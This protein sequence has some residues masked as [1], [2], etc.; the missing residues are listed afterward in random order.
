MQVMEFVYVVPR[1]QLFPDCTPHGF[2]PFGDELSEES[3]HRLAV[4]RGH[5]VERRHAEQ[6]P[7]LK[8][9]IPYTVVMRENEVFCLRRTKGGG[10]ARLHDKL[11]IGVGGHV[12]PIDMPTA[13]G[14]GSNPELRTPETHDPL[15]GAAL[16]ELHEELVLGDGMGD[17]FSIGILNDDTN[18]VGAV[19]LGLVRVLKVDGPVEV[20]ETDQLEG[21][22][23]SIS[24]LREMLAE[25]ANFETWSALL[26]QQL[27]Q[28]VLDPTPA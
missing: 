21:Q 25:G 11:S 14:G 17:S 28:L 4:E 7:N 26:V 15:P 19:H 27:D 22:F 16:R 20:R 18:P 5:F 12:N 13:E 2:V 8:Q 24:V 6:D 3:F 10:E 9:L 1:A 23:V